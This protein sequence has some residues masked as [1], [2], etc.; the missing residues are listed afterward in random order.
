[1]A[2]QVRRL[3]GGSEPALLA[4][5]LEGWSA[6]AIDEACDASGKGPLMMASWR[7][8]LGNV[9]FLLAKGC[10]VDRI[11]VGEF[12]YGKTP[13]FFAITRG[14]DEVVKLLLAHGAST[15]IVNNKGQ[16]P[17]SL[18]ASHLEPSTVAALAEA[19]GEGEWQNYR[20]SHSDGFVYGDLDRRFLDRPLAETD[21][22]VFDV[23]VNPTT[24]ATRRGNFDRNNNPTRVR[25][26]TTKKITPPPRAKVVARPRRRREIRLP[27]SRL[28]DP[29]RSLR[30]PAR[31]G[32]ATLASPPTWGLVEQQDLGPLVFFDAEFEENRLETLQLAFLEGSDLRTHVLDAAVAATI[33][34]RLFDGNRWLVGFS[35]KRDLNLL[36][37]SG[38]DFCLD[39]QHLAGCPSQP[40]SL[41]AV[42]R[43][44]LD[45]HLDKTY[46]RA[47]WTIRPLP[48][49]MLHYAALDAA[50]LAFLLP[51]LLPDD[52][53]FL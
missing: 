43:D 32:V 6:S 28:V 25:R 37:R 40:P 38:A 44:K 39:L 33:V 16:T 52:A 8:A 2:S 3:A 49:A 24:P 30:C 23:C 34:P 15:R 27:P 50:I 51:A 7:G 36:G 4:K 47:D 14:R 45:L 29:F 10:D 5:A 19:E 26:P 41:A 42:V 9:E 53:I 13:L 22:V 35:I 21:V 12:T 1:M 11:A 18:G 46:Q 20:A 17:R 48:P 31:R